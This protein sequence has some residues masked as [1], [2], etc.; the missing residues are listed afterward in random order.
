MQKKGYREQKENSAM[1]Y[2]KTNETH[3]REK[4]IELTGY[5]V[6]PCCR[7]HSEHEWLMASLDGITFDGKTIC[8]IKT[9]KKEVHDQVALGVIPEF[10]WQ[11][12]QIQMACANVDECFYVSGNGW[13]VAHTVIERDADWFQENL[14]TLKQFYDSLSDSK[15]PKPSDKDVVENTDALWMELMNEIH[16]LDSHIKSLLQKKESIKQNLI[17]LSNGKSTHGG[18]GTLRKKFKKGSIDYKSVEELS[19]LDLEKYRSPSS[20]YWSIEFDKK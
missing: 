14:D 6:A 12:V 20:E 9:N 7:V 4:F 3:L 15:P 8:E 5:N 17:E 10:H 1:R 11:Q 18:G 19:S 16:Q 13:D 2:G